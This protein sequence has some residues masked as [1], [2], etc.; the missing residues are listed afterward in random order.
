[1]PG[2]LMTHAFGPLEGMADGNRTRFG[3]GPGTEP[4][5]ETT[6]VF[7]HFVAFPTDSDRFGPVSGFPFP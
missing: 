1:M 2:A 4:E 5:A 3:I 7:R 6:G